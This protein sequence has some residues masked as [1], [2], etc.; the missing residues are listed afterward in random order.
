MDIA[1][2]NWSAV[3]K[4]FSDVS[5]PINPDDFLLHYWLA[6]KAY[7][8]KARLFKEMKSNI[9]AANAKEYL[10]R[11][12]SAADTYAVIVAPSEAK[13]AKEEKELRESLEALSIFHVAQALPLVLSI[14]QR[15]KAKVISL[16]STKKA[17]KLIE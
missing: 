13:W 9:K 17:L 5:V 11:L 6:T 14:M 8:S 7:V 2:D 15:Y 10:N 1:K 4:R 16:A 3:L 12:S